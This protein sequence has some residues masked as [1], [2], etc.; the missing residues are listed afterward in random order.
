MTRSHL[1]VEAFPSP[2]PGPEGEVS[3]LEG[4]V[5]H[6]LSL[7][8]RWLLADQRPDGHWV[9]ELEGDTILESEYVLLRHF[10]GCLDADR[11]R[12]LG[13]HLRHTQLAEG[14]WALYPGGP[15]NLSASVK[16]YLALRL[17]GLDAD[18]PEM[19]RARQI[20]LRL[21][22]VTAC[23]TFTR[24]YL[25]I[26]GQY[27][28]DGTPV[29]P[30]ELVLL[31]RWSYLNLHEI[32]SWSRAIL[33]PLAIICAHR[34]YCPLP[35]GINIDE[36]FAGGRHGPHL[37]LPWDRR[38]LSWRNF[39]LLL[40]RCLH[41]GERSGWKP[42]RRRALA[43][44]E[45]WMLERFAD[46]GGLG[47]I[48]P[49]I[50]N[51]L[52]ALRCLGYHD[53][54]PAVRSQWREIEAFEIVEEDRMRLQPCVSPIWDTALALLALTNAGIP[55]D[56]P[57]LV[58][59]IDWLL[60]KQTQKRGDWSAKRPRVE[61]G[62]WY[63]EYENEFYPDVDDTAVALMALARIHHPDQRAV[64]DAARRGLE[65]VFAMQ[66]RTGGWGSFD[67][68]NDRMIFAQIPFADHNAMLDPATADITGRVL[69]MLGH[70]GYDKRDQ[71]VA[72][73]VRFLKQEQEKD[74]SWF[75][76]WGVNYI[77]GTWQVLKGLRLIGED[78]TAPYV[79]RAVEWL[80]AVQNPDG[81]WGESCDS[82]DD[83]ALKGIGPS[84][85][86]QTAWAVMG[87]IAAGEAPSDAVRRGVNFLVR[88]QTPDGG[89][90]EPWFTGTGFP[91]VFYLRY[92]LYRNY[93]PVFALGMYAHE[94][95]MNR[96]NK[97]AVNGRQ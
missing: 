24:I 93:F 71:R 43:V 75:G 26:F 6:A 96:N 42:W 69:E 12:Q 14:G 28:W 54:D 95:G 9:G 39:F 34:P 80:R 19:V 79:R 78:M 51:A 5:R 77:Y 40:D 53:D 20:I 65:W 41:W 89:W 68:D 67:V 94:I 33:V 1:D 29:V 13:N 7:G 25:A 23:N 18:H 91:R 36:L 3:L 84:T 76:R 90:D 83:P 11:L 37:R 62:G 32:S 50:V 73:A 48:F 82:Y 60:T 56:D 55:P 17:A 35:R 63:F 30:P 85:A 72:R 4:A 81:G 15:P 70:Y 44:A 38:R 46:S 97:A 88:T 47:A 87:L 92:H 45:K 2:P 49:P 31:P 74:G 8:T 16:A 57:T 22:G 52:M 64:S 66:C 58:R 59:A 27:D 21:G 61:P 10:M 86:S